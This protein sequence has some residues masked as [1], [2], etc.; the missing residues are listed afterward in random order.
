[1][2][3]STAPPISDQDLAD[4]FARI[5]YQGDGRPTLE[6]LATLHAL[7]PQAIPFENLDPLSGSVVKLDHEA[8]QAKLVHGGRGGH[9]YEHNGLL[10]RV[11]EKL[12]F[13]VK[14][15][16]A[17]VMWFAPEGTLTPRTHMVLRVDI[18]GVSYLADVG[19]GGLVLTAPLRLD[20]QDEQPTPHEH[21][22]LVHT[23]GDICVKAGLGHEWRALYRFDLTEQLAIDYEGPNWYACTHPT[24]RFVNDLLVARAP[25]GA[26]YTLLNNQ[27]SMRSAEGKKKQALHSAD[28]LR[29]VL[30]DVFGIAVPRGDA[31]E[32]AL[33]RIILRGAHA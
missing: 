33:A 12:G 19:F 14:G 25:V 15:L 22:R 21:F 9:C 11:L 1:M 13:T 8:V 4:Y 2:T 32:A 10:K 20:T 17:R 30:E 16:V 24:S 18:D 26:R 29:S 7:H 31:T 23:N 6:T 27:L 28:E 5:A 3:T